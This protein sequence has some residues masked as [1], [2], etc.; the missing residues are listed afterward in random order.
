MVVEHA[1][2]AERLSAIAHHALGERPVAR[3]LIQRGAQ[4]IHREH[5]ARPFPTRVVGDPAQQTLPIVGFP[6]A[7][8]ANRLLDG[9]LGRQE[10][11][12]GRERHARGHRY[13]ADQGERVVP[14][15][16]LALEFLP[17]LPIRGT[18]KA[19]DVP[20]L[21]VVDRRDR[22]PAYLHCPQRRLEAAPDAQPDGERLLRIPGVVRAHFGER[23][24]DG[25]PSGI[26][27]LAVGCICRHVAT[28]T[29]PPKIPGFAL[30]GSSVLSGSPPLPTNLNA[31]IETRPRMAG[32]A[33]CGALAPRRLAER[34]PT[35]R[36][37]GVSRPSTGG[38]HGSQSLVTCECY[39]RS[40][41]VTP[42]RSSA[43]GSADRHQICLRGGNCARSS[44][45]P[46]RSE[47]V[48]GSLIAR[49]VDRSTAFRAERMHP[50]GSALR[51]LDVGLRVSGGNRNVSRGA[52]TETR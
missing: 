52:G 28:T 8:R 41:C 16:E 48:G 12:L 45:H 22:C 18:P 2:H 44:R 23:L 32:L 40:T 50:L 30:S 29:S 5:D 6:E 24:V 9:S 36:S 20:L 26:S 15:C 19:A 31:P 34:R 1:A 11:R 4:R 10:E 25:L 17:R 21:V 51:G 43:Q 3:P 38:T 47:Y 27:P 46:T 13:F 7:R 14:G 35:L 39:C 37:R 42:R 33:P 49:R